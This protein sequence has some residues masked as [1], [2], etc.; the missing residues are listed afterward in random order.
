MDITTIIVIA[1]IVAI[2]GSAIF[3]IVRAKKRGVKCIGCPA[4][5]SCSGHCCSGSKPTTPEAEPVQA[6]AVSP[7]KV[8]SEP[9]ADNKANAHTCDCSSC[10]SCCPGN[11]ADNN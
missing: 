11:N 10:S 2:L 4:G 9:T 6:E 5:S 1:V 8:G 7:T 3:Y